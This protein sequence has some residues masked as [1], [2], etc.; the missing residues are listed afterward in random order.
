MIKLLGI[1]NAIDWDNVIA[2][3]ANSEPAYIGPKHSRQDNSPAI[4]NILDMWDKA[5][6][7]SEKDGGSVAW[8]MFFPGEQFDSSVKEKFNDFF[9]LE[10]N[11]FWISRIWP[12]KVAA[13]HWDVHSNEESIPECKRY[14]CH[15]GKPEFGHIFIADD[16][17]FYGKEQG[18]TYEWP[19]R[20]I[21]HTGVNCGFTPKY[22]LNA[23]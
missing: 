16:E 19:H 21:W 5:G 15:I 14:H 4:H 8:D 10:C 12:G 9:E 3:C 17:M 13:P 11:N 6:Y 1:C 2:D 7:R 22:I 20:K 23:W 18:T